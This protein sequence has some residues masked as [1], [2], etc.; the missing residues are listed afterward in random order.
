[1]CIESLAA[2]FAAARG[3]NAA[4]YILVLFFPAE[5]F[6]STSPVN[7]IGSLSTFLKCLKRRSLTLLCAQHN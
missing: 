2:T 7:T 3:L 1:M 4:H 6:V 5:S